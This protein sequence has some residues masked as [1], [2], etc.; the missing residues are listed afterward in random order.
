MNLLL[1]F[2]TFSNYTHFY[3]I[4][5]RGTKN[6]GKKVKIEEA[7]LYRCSIG[8]KV[9]VDDET[10]IADYLI[11]HFLP[12]P[13]IEESTP[14]QTPTGTKKRTSATRRR[15]PGGDKAT[16]D[17]DVDTVINFHGALVFDTESQPYR[18]SIG[19]KV[20]VD[21]ETAIA[22]YLI[23]HFLPLQPIEES[24]PTQTPTGTKKRTSATRRRCPVGDKATT[25]D[26]VDTVINFSGALVID[27]ESAMVAVDE[28]EGA[29]KA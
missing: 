12:L 7:Q 29:E 8:F 25:D 3:R 27:T 24:T 26:D 13:P 18:C 17:D 21:D 4:G 16:T 23:K 1:F 11:K 22:D 20:N 19:F 14:T 28:S 9:N 6:I 2:L 5:L 15:S 10:A